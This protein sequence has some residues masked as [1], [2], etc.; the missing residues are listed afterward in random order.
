MPALW[1]NGA[2]GD[3]A[4]IANWN[5]NN[6]GGG[7]ASTGPASRL[8]NS[9]D[10]VKLQNGSSAV[11]LSAGAQSVRKFYTQ[12]PLN[13]TGGSLSVGYV[14]GSGGKFDVPSE[15]KAVVSLTGNGAYSAHTTIIDGG[16]GQ[17]KIGGGTVTFRSIQLASNAT[18]AGKIVMGGNVTFIP[19]TLGG[20]A[21]ATIQSTGA[22][23][24]AGTVDL[25]GA[26]RTFTIND[27]TPAVDV[28]IT[29]AI[30]GT[31]GLVKSGVGT[32]QLTATE[33]Y[34]G[35]TTVGAGLLTLSGANARLGA[36]D[37][38]VLGTTAG[39][40]LQIQTGVSN[41][42][43]NTSMLSL[44]GGGT[45][46]VADQG[47]ADLGSGIVETVNMLMLNGV[48]QGPGTYGS[49]LSSATFK[50][51][52]FFSGTGLITVL[53][54]EPASGCLMVLGLAALAVQRRRR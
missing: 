12:Q 6:P 45:A 35:S 30:I 49:S 51:N 41:A 48:A 8:P 10:W 22:L 40:A 2:S 26:T 4:T 25:G 24:Q 28:S 53:V 7:T 14:P 46:G 54:P 27:G 39:T 38:T 34:T 43:L 32:L 44:A 21:T 11:T 31:G 47:Y 37:I 1:T 52:E 9:L 33:T 42:I 29:A 5:S 16:G 20:A 36:G 19:S 18:N 15:F 3:W 17:F 23:A 50:N 13:I